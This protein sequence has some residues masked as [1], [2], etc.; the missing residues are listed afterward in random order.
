MCCSVE[1]TERFY[2]EFYSVSW[3]VYRLKVFER[4]NYICKMCELKVSDPSNLIADHITPISIGGDNWDMN[5]LQT[6]CVD[7]NK[8]KTAQ[9]M[10]V[11]SEY[12]AKEKI[13]DKNRTLE[14][15]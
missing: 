14:I 7:C 4:D 10:K 12:R 6:L 9:D 2:K 13:L 5:N 1:C 8:I 15:R 11:I 3:N